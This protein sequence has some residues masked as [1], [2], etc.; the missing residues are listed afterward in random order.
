MFG[1]TNTF[2][3]PAAQNP[4][5]G[6]GTSTFGS[7]STPSPPTQ[8]AFGGFGGQQQATPTSN[9]FGGGGV[10]TPSS[11]G[12]GSTGFGS[13]TKP[14]FG[15]SPFGSPPVTTTTGFGGGGPAFGAQQQQQQQPGLQSNPNAKGTSNPCYIPYV[16]NE[17]GGF[18]KIII[19]TIVADPS[20]P[21]YC[22][23]SF[24]ELRYE[25]YE[26]NRKTKFELVPG[27]AGQQQQP[28]S[29]FGAPSTGGFGQP[30]APPTPGGFGGFGATQPS[31]GFGGFGK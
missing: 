10:S 21:N 25:D 5:F 8:Q 28:A 6:G 15:A 3:S 7:F 4:G 22:T 27:K 18:Q 2:G 14:A 20:S 11:S 30:A 17:D 13:T 23:K 26:Q 1:T 16:N 31:T 29:A 19:H 12:F 24:E 9:T